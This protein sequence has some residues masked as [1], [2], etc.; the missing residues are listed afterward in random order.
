MFS[1]ASDPVLAQGICDYPDISLG[2]AELSAFPNGETFIQI[3]ESIQGC[4]VFIMQ[5]TH[6]AV[7][8]EIMKMLIMIDARR[9]ISASRTTAV[10]SHFGYV[11][12]DRKD[13]PRLPTTSKSIANLLVSVGVNRILT[14]DFYM[15]HTVCFF[16]IP[17]DRLLGHRLLLIT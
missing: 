10:L 14:M 15:P 8:H 13:K 2:E 17:T 5:S 7:D 1:E 12:R 3:R 6:R 16:D 11:P 4:G 9:R